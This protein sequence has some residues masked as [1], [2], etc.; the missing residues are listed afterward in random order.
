MIPG[1]EFK[2]MEFNKATSHCCGGGGGVRSA[3]PEESK[4]I[5]ATRVD[6]ALA[7]GAKTIITACPFCVSNLIFGSEDKDVKV[8]DLMEIVDELL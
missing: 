2:E 5:A 4:K 6:E 7:V 3:Y 1:I 8:I